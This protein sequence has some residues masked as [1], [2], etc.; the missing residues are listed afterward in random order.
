MKKNTYIKI[1]IVIFMI[2]NTL[3]FMFPKWHEGRVY[4]PVGL[5]VLSVI[6]VVYGLIFGK[7]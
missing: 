6:I 5:F 2:I 3:N 7:K 1:G 4:Y